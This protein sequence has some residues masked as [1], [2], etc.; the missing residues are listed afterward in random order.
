[1]EK[2]E[3]LEKLAD[4][5]CKFFYW[6]NAVQGVNPEEHEAIT[7]IWQNVRAALEKYHALTGLTLMH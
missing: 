3:I 4:L 1:M 6:K 5:E 2:H 7:E